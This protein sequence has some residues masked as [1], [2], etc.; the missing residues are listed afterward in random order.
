MVS[1]IDRM[2]YYIFENGEFQVASSVEYDLW[3]EKKVPGLLLP[4]QEISVGTIVHSIESRYNG[5]VDKG[6][7][8]YPFILIHF[9]DELVHEPGK[10]IYQNLVEEHTEHYASLQNYTIAHYNICRRLQDLAQ[11]TNSG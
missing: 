5:C 6:E 3:H 7:G 4:D 11:K 9:E 10:G 1:F 2:R 8:L